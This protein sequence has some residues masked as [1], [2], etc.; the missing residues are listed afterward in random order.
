MRRV[1]FAGLVLVSVA[2]PG[3]ALA[4]Y[5]PGPTTTTSTTTTTVATTTTAPGVTTT[6]VVQTG[7]TQVGGTV[8][9]GGQ[10]TPEACG[11]AAGAS[12]TISLNGTGLT[13]QQADANGCVQPRVEVLSETQV[14]VA[15]TTAAGRCGPNTLTATGPSGAGTH[16]Q[17]VT[18]TVV[19]PAARAGIAFTGANVLRWSGLGVALV[20]LGVLLVLAA[21][22]RRREAPSGP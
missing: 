2:L 10:L 7:G 11:F 17:T 15:G 4:Q 22:A 21:R 20:G 18:F 1:V 14:R 5:P 8:N 6:T 9:V 19:C 12:V 13:T 16:T 3:A